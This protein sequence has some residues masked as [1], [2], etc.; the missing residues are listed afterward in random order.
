MYVLRIDVRLELQGSKVSSVST[1]TG[2]YK[3]M[4]VGVAAVIEVGW[5]TSFLA[6]KLLT[7]MEAAE[8]GSRR[9]AERGSDAAEIDRG[10][11]RG[12][13][14]GGAAEVSFD[15]LSFFP[16]FAVAASTDCKETLK[17][18]EGTTT[19]TNSPLQCP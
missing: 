12:S 18:L 13:P 19:I 2:S 1:S 10:S 16:F 8:S 5:A 11:C 3:T 9:A 6:P 15:P 4:S 17:D 7:S 14:V